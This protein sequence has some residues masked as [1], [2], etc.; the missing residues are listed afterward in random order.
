[1]I[2]DPTLKVAIAEVH[3]E[4]WDGSVHESR[5]VQPVVGVSG[6]EMLAAQVGSMLQAAGV[7]M[8]GFSFA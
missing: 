7:Q 6:T 1:M 4:G 5:K 8:P 3:A 2:A